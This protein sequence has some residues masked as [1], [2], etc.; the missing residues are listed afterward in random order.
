MKTSF[1]LALI[2]SAALSFGQSDAELTIFAEIYDI[3]LNYNRTLQ[4]NAMVLLKEEGVDLETYQKLLKLKLEAKDVPKDDALIDALDRVKDKQAQLRLDLLQTECM[5]RKFDIDQ[6]IELE[7]RYKT[8]FKFN[9]KVSS[10]I[11]AAKRK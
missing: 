11:L 6:Y 9:Q 10:F 3:K 8:D 2:F 5:K 1:F 4:S 7:K